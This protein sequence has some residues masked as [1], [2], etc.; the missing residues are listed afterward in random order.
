MARIVNSTFTPILTL[1]VKVLHEDGSSTIK[2]LKVDDEVTNLR[3]VEN[4]T[5][6]KATGRVADLTYTI[7]NKKVK[8]YYTNP[9]K[10]RSY[11]EYDVTPDTIVIDCSTLKHSNLITIPVREILE[12]EGDTD[13]VRIITW[14]S[15]GISGKI[16]MSDNVINTFDLKEGQTLTNLKFLNKGEE[17]ILESADLIAMHHDAALNLLALEMRVNSKPRE[18]A[19]ERIVSIG[20]T[21]DFITPYDFT[22][23]TITNVPVNGTLTLTDG[24]FTSPIVLTKSITIKGAKAGVSAPGSGRASSEF[25][26]NLTGETILSGKIST[27]EDIDITIDGVALTGDAVL[28]IGKARSLTLKNCIIKGIVPPS[29]RDFFIRTDNGTDTKIVVENCIFGAFDTS[30]E[31][32]RIYNLFE[33]NCDLQD[34]SAFVNNRF[35]KGC[36]TNNDI[37]IYNAEEGATITISNNIWEKSANGIRVGT[38]GNP[39]YNVIVRDNE[40]RDTDAGDYAG[41]LLIQP[42]GKQTTSMAGATI[43]IS[44]TKRTDTDHI[45]YAYSGTNDLDM[46][47]EKLPTVYVDGQ[48]A[49]VKA[50]YQNHATPPTPVTPVI[51]GDNKTDDDI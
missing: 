30:I 9:A 49:D 37:C 17:A 28:S 27:T 44:G 11:F 23:T 48:L 47:N 46:D 1:N 35:Q 25:V 15:Y 10:L 4:K 5:I 39:T 33:M 13:V 40:Y 24:L 19:A 21:V 31:G 38:K 36:S 2:R 50:V 32:R 3:Y 26:G 51:D 6:K 42:Y 20:G 18:I 22:E 8:R 41:L 7:P 34:G 45:F 29:N 43:N 12:D 16:E 14:F